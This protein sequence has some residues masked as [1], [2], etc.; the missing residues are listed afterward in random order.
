MHILNLYETSRKSVITLRK[1]IALIIAMAK[2]PEKFS[3]RVTG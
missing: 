2:N 3:M 1:G